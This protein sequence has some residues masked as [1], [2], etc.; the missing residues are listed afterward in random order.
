M[1]RT[2]LN[3]LLQEISGSLAGITFRRMYG[4]QTIIKKPDMSQVNWSPAQA[5]HRQR[6]KEAVAYARTA[7]ADPQIRA[8][9]DESAAQKGKRAFDLAVSDYFKG[10]NL[11]NR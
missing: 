8:R 3:P 1:P 5:A 4:K 2:K 9:Y 11:L 7:L 6:F 10:E